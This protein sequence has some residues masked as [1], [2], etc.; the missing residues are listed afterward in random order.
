MWNHPWI[1][2]DGVFQLRLKDVG[3]CQQWYSEVSHYLYSYSYMYNNYAS[4]LKIPYFYIHRD[5]I[6]ISCTVTSSKT[7]LLQ[8]LNTIANVIIPSP[9]STKMYSFV[10]T[11]HQIFWSIEVLFLARTILTAP[12]LWI[13]FR[14]GSTLDHWLKWMETLYELIAAAPLLSLH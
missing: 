13:S 3:I 10:K 7:F 12:R 1:V 2:V 14:T 4:E 9:T 8:L 5:L 6:N 11:R